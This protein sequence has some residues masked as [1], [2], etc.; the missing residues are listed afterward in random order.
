MVICRQ[1]VAALGRPDDFLRVTA[2]RV[3]GDG[4]R[5]N[6]VTGTHMASARIA[7]SFFI[8]AD[9]EGNITDSAPEIR[10]QY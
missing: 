3:T 8:T 2:R 9:E 5:V 1:V 7:H 6:V 4:Y 10:K